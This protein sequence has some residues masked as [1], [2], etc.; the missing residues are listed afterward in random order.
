MGF[1]FYRQR[2]SMFCGVACLQMI[3]KHYGRN[4]DQDKLSNL[5]VPTSEGVSLLSLIDTAAQLGLDATSIRIPISQF[6]DFFYRAF[7]I[8]IKTIL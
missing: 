6:K 5:C 4:I 2:D 8:G 3:C 7:F 1:K